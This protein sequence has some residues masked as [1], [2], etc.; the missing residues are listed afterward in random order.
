M[1]TLKE[2][3]RITKKKYYEKNKEHLLA[4]SKAATRA[5]LEDPLEREKYLEKKRVYS[6]LNFESR[7]LSSVKSKC[8]TDSIPFDLE[9]EDIKIPSHCPK[10]GVPLVIHLE[11]GKF[12]D[13]PSIDR[14]DPKLGYTKTN[15]QI[16]CLWYNLAKLHWPE[17]VFFNMC[18]K[19]VSFNNE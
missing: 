15:I 6:R 8:K 19:V 2:R 14:I 1:T 13:T 17:E 3:N 5:R 11:R 10:T 12:W 16:V 9:I 4:M 18:K 7:L